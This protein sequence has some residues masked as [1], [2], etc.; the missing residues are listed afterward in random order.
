M[1]GPNG[2]LIPGI[3]GLTGQLPN[4]LPINIAGLNGLNG[5][6]NLGALNQLT[7]LNALQGSNQRPIFLINRKV[8]WFSWLIPLLIILGAPLILGIFFIPMALKSTLFVLQVLRNLGMTDLQVII[9]KLRKIINFHYLLGVLL[10]LTA[11]LSGG[12]AAA[13]ANTLSQATG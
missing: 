5:L 8:D 9:H 4:Q 3:A 2:N 1:I 10:P 11:A 7:A 6:N 12:T 13:A